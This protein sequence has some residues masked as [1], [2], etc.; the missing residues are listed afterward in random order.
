MIG[1]EV[2]FYVSGMEHQPEKIIELIQSYYAQDS[3]EYQTF[4]RYTKDDTDVS[5]L[6][7]YN[8]EIY[9]KVY[10]ADEGRDFDNRHPY[11]YIRIQ[12]R[13]DREAGERVLFR[14]DLA[15]TNTRVH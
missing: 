13:Y 12:V 5:T 2:A 1:A 6:P 4:T 7:W 10:L 3:K 15:E 9:M 14:W 11:P 8:Q